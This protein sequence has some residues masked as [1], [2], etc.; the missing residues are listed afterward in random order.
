MGSE[1]RPQLLRMRFII[2]HTVCARDLISVG[3]GK[4]PD[5]EIRSYM[6]NAG[7]AVTSKSV[8]PEKYAELAEER[9]ITPES[10]SGKRNNK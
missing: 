10:I 1:S 7:L 8:S 3:R 9:S 4:D 6:Y 5:P 2:L